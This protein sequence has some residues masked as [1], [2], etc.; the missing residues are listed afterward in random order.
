VP[1]GYLGNTSLENILL[2]DGSFGG[3]L[4]IAPLLTR[5][6]TDVIADTIVCL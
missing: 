1:N 5:N 6:V 4:P 2:I 3:N